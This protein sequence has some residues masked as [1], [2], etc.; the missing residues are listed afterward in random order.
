MRF[1]PSADTAIHPFADIPP[2]SRTPADQPA[3]ARDLTD[4]TLILTNSAALP[5]DALVAGG[6]PASRSYLR[7][8]IP[9]GILDSGTVVRATLL[10]T[11]RPAAG[12]DVRDTFSVY[13]QVVVAGVA[14]T[15]I[16]RALEF[17]GPSPGTPGSGTG[18]LD[19]LALDSIRLAP[20]DS[21][22]HALEMVKV[23]QAWRFRP[24]TLA[25]RAIALRS[26]L[27]GS[28]THEALFFSSD[29]PPE[30]R[31][32]LRIS[33]VPRIPFGLP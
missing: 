13:P 11:Q 8:D 3:A 12:A 6:L 2:S 14:V 5:S 24:D 10:L 22:S 26:S 25:P 23:L 28:S 19:P 17:L 15:D 27:E 1:D 21:G 32:Q 20:G 9:R 18:G 33:Y 4:Y 31:P 7:F 30:L 29:A 16:A